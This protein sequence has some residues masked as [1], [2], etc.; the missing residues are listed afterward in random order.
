MVRPAGAGQ[1]G[2]LVAGRLSETGDLVL[3][4]RSAGIADLLAR[5]LLKVVADRGEELA[6]GL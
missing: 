2:A 3:V 6:A 4:R 1:A 5:R